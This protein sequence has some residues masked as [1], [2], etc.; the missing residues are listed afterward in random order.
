MADSD[1]FASDT[2]DDEDY[3]VVK[4]YHMKKKGKD[5]SSSEDEAYADMGL[6]IRKKR[7]KLFLGPQPR[8]SH[9]AISSKDVKGSDRSSSEDEA[10]DDIGDT[11]RKK[12]RELSQDPQP[13]PSHQAISSK[14]VESSDRSSSEDEAFDDIGDAMRKKRREL[15]QDPQPGP[16]HQAI[17]SKDV[18][19]SD[20]SSS[21]DEAFDDIGDAMRKKRRKLFQDPQPGTSHQAISSKGVE[22]SEE[23]LDE[24]PSTI[25]HPATDKEAI[26]DS[27]D[28]SS[29]EHL[30]DIEI[31]H[32][33]SA[34]GKRPLPE[35]L[36]DVNLSKED[37]AEFLKLFENFATEKFLGSIMKS[38]VLA[39]PRK[40]ITPRLKKCP[41][42]GCP[43]RVLNLN[44]H[45][46]QCHKFLTKVRFLKNE[47]K[48]CFEREVKKERDNIPIS[49]V[50][51]L[52]TSEQ[53][54]GEKSSQLLSDE[55]RQDDPMLQEH[56]AEDNDAMPLEGLHNQGDL[57]MEQA[58]EEQL[59]SNDGDKESFQHSE[60][61]FSKPFS[62]LLP[63][64]LS[65]GTI[66]ST[67]TEGRG[68]DT[69]LAKPTP[70]KMYA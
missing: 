59:L 35:M 25:H 1:L 22:S 64:D 7:R 19:S 70:S 40:K 47:K 61:E 5:I 52:L 48:E 31:N 9:Q 20:R 3:D 49:I 41:I 2:G 57:A 14:D 13:G 27:E 28:D 60:S 65:V 67:K 69:L 45:L 21:E 62:E 50:K 15:F 6:S 63:D 16:S 10:F 54:L 58:V 23:T 53:E 56:E 55:E 4:D 39:R 24:E 42:G 37:Q 29:P 51:K 43:G 68:E 66:L 18:E 17:S 12:R 30:T 33:A 11:M 38:A 32:M 44:R 8:P 26:N 34:F 36:E 46:S